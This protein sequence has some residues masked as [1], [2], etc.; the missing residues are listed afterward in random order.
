[1][2]HS[3]TYNFI[4]NAALSVS[5]FLYPLITYPYVTR[6]LGAEYYGKVVFASYVAT[7]VSMFAQLGIPTYGIRACA[8]CRNDKAKL[9]KT[10]LEILTL[11]V[12]TALLVYAV[13]IL[14][15]FLVPR[16]RQDPALFLIIT[17][18]VLLNAFGADWFYKGLEE[19][20][21][22][23]ARDTLFR[24]LSIIVLFLTMHTRADYRIYGVMI[25][26]A[27][28]GPGIMNFLRLRKLLGG[29]S[30]GQAAQAADTV[31][32]DWQQ[33]VKPVLTFFM[34]SV[35]ISI[36]TSMDVVMLGFLSSDTQVGY[37]GA[38]TRM[39]AL[40]VSFVTALGGVL[41]PRVS[42]Y[43]AEGKEQEFRELVKKN[44]SFVL[45]V[46]VPMMV[47]LAGAADQV[48][49][50]LSGTDFAGAVLPMQVISVTIVMIA[51]TNVMGMQILVPSG[52]E[53]LTTV[54]TIWGACVNLVVNLLMIPKFGAMGAVIGT[55][56]AELT[57]LAVQTFFLRKELPPFFD[58]IEGGKLLVAVLAA[59]AGLIITRRILMPVPGATL[60]ASTVP[61]A[62]VPASTV[63]E[64]L[65]NLAVMGAVFCLVY[66]AVLLV[67]REKGSRELLGKLRKKRRTS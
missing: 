56:L 13:F 8:A 18:P 59:T 20:G 65:L 58:G 62:T 14:T 67:T 33:H 36:Y 4:M 17:I 7:W 63:P 50:L 38:A 24:V 10:V 53:K 6:V 28:G 46:S 31:R 22:V 64:Y 5:S 66:G 42:N 43:L 61:A 11:N 37:Y 52:R 16:F 26:V 40:A 55:V 15:L 1:M 49:F 35:A 57:V 51:L 48:I 39:K 19:Y 30:S 27:D 41:M 29:F 9:R 45:L 12:I 34:L 32:I 21:Y 60:P 25:A 47:F 3:I 54:S 44:F 2:P 23:A